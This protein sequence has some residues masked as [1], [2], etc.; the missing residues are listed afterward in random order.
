MSQF[1]HRELTEKII[2]VYYNVYNNLSHTYPEFIYE[3]AMMDDLRH[4]G[5]SCVRQDEYEIYYKDWLVGKQRLDIFVANEVVVELKV[6]P[7]LTPLHQAQTIS[8]LK[9]TGKQVGLLLNFGG[10]T[11]E[12]KR[13]IFT[14]DF[15]TYGKS[16]LKQTERISRDLL[17]PQLSYQIIGGLFEV[18]RLLGPGYIH[19]IY[20][21]ATYR[22][23]QAMGLNAIPQKKMTV[24]YRNK[25]VGN[26][27]L[28]HLLIEDK[29]MLFP[30]AV[31]DIQQLNPAN[32]RLWAQSQK[33]SLGILAN[34]YPAQLA[35]V[36]MRV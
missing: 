12:I 1:L 9:T 29:I 2:G 11:P 30:V 18:H 17:F 8:Y 5:I 24:F 10:S 32:L 21:N 15:L 36:F 4:A 14:K 34:F 33:V 6:V 3:N 20:A 28:G 16:S 35:L 19:R 7:K 25:S 26:I 13:V 23:M 22:E 27:S 31:K